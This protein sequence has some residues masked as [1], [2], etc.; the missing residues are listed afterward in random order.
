MP[1]HD[2]AY[3]PAPEGTA[4]PERVF[5]SELLGKER[6]LLIE[7]RGHEYLLSEAAPDGGLVLLPT[8][9]DCPA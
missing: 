9:R 1:T 5:A 4:H 3:R 6:M 7:H 8:A 2:F